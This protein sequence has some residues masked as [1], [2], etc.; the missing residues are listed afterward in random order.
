[1]GLSRRIRQPRATEPCDPVTS[2]LPDS[3]AADPRSLP[4]RPQRSRVGLP[5]VEIFGPTV[6]GEGPAAG[7]PA[8]FIRFGGCDFRCAWCDSLHA[9]EPAEVRRA[10]RLSIDDVLKRLGGLR[11]GPRLVVLTGG[12]PVLLELGALVGALHAVDFEVAVETQGSVWRDW[13]TQVDNLV[14]SPKPPSSGMATTEH[15]RSFEAF[16]GR[17]RPGLPPTTLK[18][19]VFDTGDL[20]FARRVHAT[21][22]TLPLLLSTGTDVGLSEIETLTRLSERFRWLCEATAS[23]VDLADVRVLPQLHVIAWG[24]TRGV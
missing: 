2:P 4:R 7:R 11:P 23:Q 3:N 21:A 6:Q 13:L 15:I 9:V 5:V 14:V 10:L 1:M 16:L 24:T 17:L 12:N 8:Y 18:V 20:E 19:V 22:P